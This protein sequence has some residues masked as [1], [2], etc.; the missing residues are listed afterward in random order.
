[1]ASRLSPDALQQVDM[2]RH[3]QNEPV[4]SSNNGDAPHTSLLAPRSYGRRP[5][6]APSNAHMA[7]STLKT[8]DEPEIKKFKPIQTTAVA[9]E[10]PILKSLSLHSGDII[11]D[12]NAIELKPE[13]LLTKSTSLPPTGSKPEGSMMPPPM[14]SGATGK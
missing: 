5:I 6:K 13:P 4:K 1:M 10:K 8:L 7:P 11:E 2:S 12:S 14:A 9:E 3:V